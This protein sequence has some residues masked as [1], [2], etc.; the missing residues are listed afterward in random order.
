MRQAKERNSTGG[1]TRAAERAFEQLLREM[2]PELKKVISR[3][4]ISGADKDDVLQEARI[5][6]AKAVDDFKEEGGLTFKNF[7]V[8]L[9]CKRHLI[10]TI[11]QALRKKY[12]LHKNALWLAT[13]IRSAEGDA[14][15]TLE[16]F[17]ED[18][19]IQSPLNHILV[20][21]ENSEIQSMMLG[22]LTGLETS[23][24]I[25]Y[26]EHKTYKEIAD[27]LHVSPKVVDNALMRIRKKLKKVYG[28]YRERQNERENFDAPLF[29][30]LGELIPESAG[31]MVE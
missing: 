24:F 9:C 25:E 10:T 22:E 31:T 21:E 15:Q 7:S 3:F 20:E 23:I 27:F 14:E 2:E 30:D 26:L 6:F 11:N 18:K 28:E 17:I 16:D 12:E 5:G 13:P 8:N 4:Y 1:Y 19:S 29:P